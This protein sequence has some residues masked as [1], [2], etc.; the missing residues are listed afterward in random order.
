MNLRSRLTAL[1][2]ILALVGCAQVT[3][4][5]GQAPAVPHSPENVHDRDTGAGM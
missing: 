3:T 4:R 2:A 5:Q 1:L